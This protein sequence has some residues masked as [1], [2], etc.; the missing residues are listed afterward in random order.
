MQRQLVIEGTPRRHPFRQH[1]RRASARQRRASEDSD[2]RLFV[3]SFTAFFVC[4][5]TFLL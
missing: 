4:F 3:L 1:V 2:L 5:Y